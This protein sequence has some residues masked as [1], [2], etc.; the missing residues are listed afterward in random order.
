MVLD[1][2]K[3]IKFKNFEVW[4]SGPGNGKIFELAAKKDSRIKYLG[5]V[6]DKKLTKLYQKADIFLNPRPINMYGNQFNFPSKLFDYLAWNKPI[7]STSFQ[8]V[9]E[10]YS[11]SF[12]F[13]FKM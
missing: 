3:F 1:A 5:L 9:F 2:I 7:I 11:N 8:N 6:T 12:R 4:F 10:K 13:F